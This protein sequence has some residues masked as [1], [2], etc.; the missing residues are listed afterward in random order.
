MLQN[1]SLYILDKIL[2]NILNK[3]KG[4]DYGLYYFNK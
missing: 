2:Y 4:C 3:N 1:K